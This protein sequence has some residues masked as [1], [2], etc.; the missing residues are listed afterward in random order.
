MLTQ[1]RYG[2]LL[3]LTGIVLSGCSAHKKEEAE[4]RCIQTNE[5]M[6]Y[7][8]IRDLSLSDSRHEASD[9]SINIMF[10]P[11]AVLPPLPDGLV[12][13]NISGTKITDLEPVRGKRIKV[14]LMAYTSV[15]NIDP[16]VGL[17]LNFL[18]VEDVQVGSIEPLRG[19]PLWGIRMGGNK[20]LRDI[21]PLRGMQLRFLSLYSCDG[22]S[23]IDALCDMPLRQLVV[24]LCSSLKDF[25]VLASLQ[26]LEALSLEGSCWVTNIS[27]VR[28]KA[29]RVLDI[30]YTQVR[31][32]E[33]LRRMPLMRLNMRGATNITDVSALRGM[34]LEELWFTPSR[35]TN[36][37]A[38][39][40]AIKTM[41]KI[42]NVPAAEFWLR[43]DKGERE[44]GMERGAGGSE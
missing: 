8:F 20:R 1:L 41:K 32:I 28:G 35:V 40:R 13:L 18:D 27:E 36:G 11:T 5:W 25:R 14:L 2:A 6:P 17:P 3:T 7:D 24:G 10:T 26:S 37:I 30:S 34:P 9:K 31:D 44:I 39:V 16:L 12:R 21:E 19:M 29:L 15:T 42:N 23:N 33:V 22:V 43:Y 4:S 38:E